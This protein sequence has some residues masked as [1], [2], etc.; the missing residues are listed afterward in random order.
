MVSNQEI[1]GISSNQTLA[2]LWVRNNV[3]P[4]YPETRLRYLLVGN[5]VLSYYLDRDRQSWY[6]LVPAMHQITRALTARNI[7]D[8]KV[9]TPLAMDV[10][11]STFPPSSGKFRPDIS[12]SVM[13]PLLHFLNSTSSYFFVDVYPYFPWSADPAN[14]SVDYA[15]FRGGN[16]LY[17]DPGSGLTYTNLLDQMLDSMIHAMSKLGFPNIPLLIAETG[18]PNSGDIDQ[19]GANINNAATYNRNLVKKLTSEPPIGTPVRPGSIIPTF[20][21]SLYDEDQKPGQGTERHWGVFRPTGEPVYKVDLSSGQSESDHY[22][23]PAPENNTPYEGK[24]WCVVAE[25]VN[26]KELERALDYACDQGKGTCA[27]I[28]PGKECY[29]PV[30]VVRHASYA[31]SAYWAKFRVTGANC[32]FN[33]LATQTAEDPSKF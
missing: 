5:E 7:R 33:G 10:L 14:M 15:L 6:D 22:Q 3:V 19:I 26:M 20:I 29:E 16:L 27:S 23:L 32:Y 17:T 12:D 9:G 8:I 11:D 1:S 30:S 28:R 31:F 13:L 24:A 25:G 21:F 4:Y 2:D 18:W